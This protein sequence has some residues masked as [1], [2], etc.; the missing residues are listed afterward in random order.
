MS[1]ATDAKPSWFAVITKPKTHLLATIATFVIFVTGVLVGTNISE[2]RLLFYV[3]AIGVL[4]WWYVAMMDRYRK[5]R[6][7]D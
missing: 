7:E 6:S 2:L 3:P 5:A 4:L 1:N